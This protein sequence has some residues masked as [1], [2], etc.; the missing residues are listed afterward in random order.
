M[1][2]SNVLQAIVHVTMRQ[3]G[4]KNLRQLCDPLD[5]KVPWDRSKVAYEGGE[6][7]TV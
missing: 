6:W 3:N 4:H 1:F 2:P 5:I 7:L